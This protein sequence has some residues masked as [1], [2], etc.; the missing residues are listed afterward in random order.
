MSTSV[1]EVNLDGLVGPSHHYAGL[2]FGNEASLK[3]RAMPSSPRHAAIQGLE[4]AWQVARMGIPQAVLPP[5]NRPRL[6]WLTELGFVGPPSVVLSRVSQEAPQ[7][8]SA[9]YS[10]SLIHI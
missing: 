10:L 1:V 9:A 3:H 8:L 2:A 4:K 7:L 6:D 5:Q